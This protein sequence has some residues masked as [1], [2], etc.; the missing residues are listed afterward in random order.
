MFVSHVMDV[1]L[2]AVIKNQFRWNLKSYLFQF[3]QIS[4]FMYTLSIHHLWWGTYRQNWHFFKTQVILPYWK[5]KKQSAKEEEDYI[6]KIFRQKKISGYWRNLERALM[7]QSLTNAK[8][9][10]IFISRILHRNFNQDSTNSSVVF[11]VWDTL[12]M[13]T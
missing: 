13:A 5:L 1:F 3:E 10:G 4:S 7:W 11:P 8:K 2:C 12:K 9:D 6:H